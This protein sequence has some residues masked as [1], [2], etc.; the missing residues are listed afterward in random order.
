MA[1]LFVPRC[2]VEKLLDKQVNVLDKSTVNMYCLQDI[3]A[4]NKGWEYKQ[5]H[6][7]GKLKNMVVFVVT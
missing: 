3:A 5:T 4:Y 7:L 2:N 1:N 6:E